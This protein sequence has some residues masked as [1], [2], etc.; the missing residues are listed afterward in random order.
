MIG[1]GILDNDLVVVESRQT[2]EAGQTVVALIDDGEATVKR[3]FT[4]RGQV[5]LESAN[6]RYKPIVIEPPNRVKIQG[7]VIGVI[8]RYWAN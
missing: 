2:A 7:I 8:R 4:K 6:P 3:F 5:R 1:E